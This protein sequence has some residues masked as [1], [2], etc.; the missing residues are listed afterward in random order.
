MEIQSTAD[1]GVSDKRE[2]WTGGE[3]RRDPAGRAGSKDWSGWLAIV[4]AGRREV[5]CGRSAGTT[6]SE[7]RTSQWYDS[8]GK[9]GEGSDCGREVPH[10]REPR[11]GDA[12][13]EM[14]SSFL[15]GDRLLSPRNAFCRVL[16]TRPVDVQQIEEDK[17]QD[18][19]HGARP[20]EQE[21]RVA[22][23]PHVWYPAPCVLAAGLLPEK[24]HTVGALLEENRPSSADS[25]TRSA[26]VC[27][28]WQGICVK[29]KQE[30]SHPECGEPGGPSH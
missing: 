4:L 16:E 12:R 11:C 5:L 7:G 22:E 20:D 30:V 24:A 14:L 25:N 19:D 23:A 1:A 27:L 8:G 17:R 10:S 2:H 9:R 18:Q 26:S 28:N 29:E 21:T 15:G 13:V 6:Y 3:L